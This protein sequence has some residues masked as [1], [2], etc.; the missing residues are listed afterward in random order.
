MSKTTYTHDYYAKKAKSEG[1]VARSVYKLHEIH[2]KYLS[3]NTARNI[4]DLGAAPGS[5]SQYLQKHI[6]QNAQIIA[7]DL[8]PLSAVLKP[9]PKITQI[10]ADFTEPDIIE[11]LISL[12]PYDLVLSDAAPSTTGNRSTDT[13]LSEQLVETIA[14]IAQKSL[15]PNGYMVAKIFQGQGMTTLLKELRSHYSKVSCM[16]PKAVRPA[17]FETYLICR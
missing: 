13:A 11:Q 15:N 7:V 14:Y 9:S 2:N 16:K 3:L 10:Q 1:F 17:S 6:S 4:L 12:G 5:W 8:Q